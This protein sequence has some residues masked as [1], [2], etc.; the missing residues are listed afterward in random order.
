MARI[1]INVGEF[2]G[3]WW[4]QGEQRRGS[5]FIDAQEGFHEIG[6]AHYNAIRFCVTHEINRVKITVRNCHQAIVTED[7]KSPSICFRTVPI[8]V[9]PREYA[10]DWSVVFVTDPDANVSDPGCGVVQLIPAMK[11]AFSVGYDGRFYIEVDG[12]GQLRDFGK[13]P[14]ASV[15]G[16]VLVLNN[17]PFYVSVGKYKG[18]W[19]I[20]YVTRFGERTGGVSLNAESRDDFEPVVLV[21]GLRYT[22]SVGY[23]GR[24][25]FDLDDAGNIHTE[26]TDSASVGSLSNGATVN[27]VLELK[28]ALIS[29]DRGDYKGAW[30]LPWVY[31]IEFHGDDNSSALYVVPALEYEFS[32]GYD[33]RF[34]FFVDGDGSVEVDKPE[35]AYD[36]GSTLALRCQ[37]YKFK[38]I[39]GQSWLLPYVTDTIAHD[40]A[41]II[42]VPALSYTFRT[43]EGVN[44][45]FRALPS[46]DV[47]SAHFQWAWP[48]GDSP[49]SPGTISNAPS[50]EFL[51][52]YRT[53]D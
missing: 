16:G 7:D 29:I 46:G 19:A 18:T 27:N 17:C 47:A 42:L 10:G 49:D 48:P 50:D 23:Y 22:F 8:K 41:E 1:F 13:K 45:P 38:V 53:K 4:W 37:S 35:S 24:F 3:Y 14:W 51:T 11:Y 28:N 39:K 5:N 52:R 43:N 2:Q 26:A 25:V 40:Y 6:I 21:P 20:S 34:L 30:G 12:D 32:V 36:D 15:V 33:G 31:P 44:Y 9:Q